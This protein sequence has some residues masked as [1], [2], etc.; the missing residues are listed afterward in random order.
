MNLVKVGYRLVNLDL[1]T[2]G[3][4]GGDSV[5]IYFGEN[6]ARF[7]TKYTNGKP[8]ESSVNDVKKIKNILAKLDR[9]TNFE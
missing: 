9:T 1:M 4:I 3:Y 7:E 5:V 2:H 8:I 6:H